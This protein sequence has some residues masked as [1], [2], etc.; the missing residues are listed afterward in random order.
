LK[1]LDYPNLVL[2]IFLMEIMTGFRQFCVRACSAKLLGISC[3]CGCG[4]FGQAAMSEDT[5]EVMSGNLCEHCVGYC[6][7]HIAL[8]IDVPE[9]ISDFDDIRWYLLHDG[10]GVFVEDDQWYLQIN[11]T[12]RHLQPDFRCGIY[13]T[14]PQ[15]C[16][17]YSTDN[18]DY[19]SGDYGY[20][21]HFLSAEHLDHF[22]AE[23]IK[24]P[25]KKSAKSKTK[26]KVKKPA[27]RLSLKSLL[28]PNDPG[29]AFNQKSVDRHGTPL[30]VLGAKR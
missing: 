14:R 1:V 26:A 12:C 4:E 19:H 10:V 15:I 20:Q 25:G 8:P 11:V 24:T 22:I 6:C 9:K 5:G 27:A 13:E 3:A 18:C 2:M 17:D 21:H 7:R 16:R 23:N 30:P 28:R 29:L